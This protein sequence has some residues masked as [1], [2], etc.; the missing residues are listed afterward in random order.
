MSQGE[1]RDGEW[2]QFIVYVREDDEYLSALGFSVENAVHSLFL[3]L[4]FLE[5]RKGDHSDSAYKVTT[6]DGQVFSVR[7]KWF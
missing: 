1:A 2:Q 7:E 3:G 5:S 4:G 6:K